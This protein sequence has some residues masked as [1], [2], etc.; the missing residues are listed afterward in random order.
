MGKV[1]IHYPSTDKS[2]TVLMSS[3]LLAFMKIILM[4]LKGIKLKKFGNEFWGFSSSNLTHN[5]TYTG[6]QQLILIKGPF[7]T[8][9][10]WVLTFIIPFLQTRKLKL[11]D[12]R[13]LAQRPKAGK[14]QN[15]KQKTGWFPV[16]LKPLC[17]Q[18]AVALF[19]RV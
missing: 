2:Q 12:V 16:H 4:C 3:G 8:K 19:T 6:Q 15:K 14:R 1:S 10:Y 17:P 13:E 9:F 5:N 7:H 11:R 18:I